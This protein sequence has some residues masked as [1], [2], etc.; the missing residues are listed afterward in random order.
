MGTK[1]GTLGQLEI[2]YF[3]LFLYCKEYFK[4]MNSE[5]WS[6]QICLLYGLPNSINSLKNRH[7]YKVNASQDVIN[8][9]MKTFYSIRLLVIC[10]VCN[11][12]FY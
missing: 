7:A 9:S 4:N 10:L 6:F 3:Y 12:N 2:I 8:N 1:Q 11:V 5:N